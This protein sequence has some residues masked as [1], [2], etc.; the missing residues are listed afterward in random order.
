MIVDVLL[1]TDT[2]L[3]LGFLFFEHQTFEELGNKAPT[4]PFDYL[5]IKLKRAEPSRRHWR[6]VDSLSFCTEP[7]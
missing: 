1:L 4:H 7:P 5:I 2:K 6:L 3:F